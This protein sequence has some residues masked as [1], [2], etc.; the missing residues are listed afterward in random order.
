MNMKDNDAA[1]AECVQRGLS[2]KNKLN[3]EGVWGE[4]ESE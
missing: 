3:N 4:T 2:G 1:L